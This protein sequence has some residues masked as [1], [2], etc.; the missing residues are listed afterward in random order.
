MHGITLDQEDIKRLVA[1]FTILQKMDQEAKRAAQSERPNEKQ[2]DKKGKLNYDKKAR[3]TAGP[4]LLWII[5]Y[6]LRH[7]KNMIDT[8][9]L[10]LNSDTYIITNPERFIPSARWALETSRGRH[11][12]ISKQNPTAKEL[13]A[14]I[15]KPRLTL[16]HRVSINGRYDTILKVELSLPKL[17]FG[18]NI[19]ELRLKDFVPLTQ[20]LV[21]VLATMGVLTTAQALAQAPMSKVHYSKNI[22]LT[23]GSTPHYYIS[24]IKEANIKFSLDVNQ[25]DYR[26][27]GHSF[28]WHCNSYEVAFYDKMHDL[29]DHIKTKRSQRKKFELLRMEVRLNKRQKMQALFK[30]LGIKTNLTLKS[31]FKP[32]TA[33]KVLLHYLDEVESKRPALLDYKADD[34][35]LLAALLVHNPTMTSKQILYIYGLKKALEVVSTREL[36]SMFEKSAQRSWSRLMAD[37]QKVKLPTT[38]NQF[39][40]VR[41]QLVKFKPLKTLKEFQMNYA[42]ENQNNPPK[43]LPH[44]SQTLRLK[45]KISEIE[46]IIGTLSFNVKGNQFYYLIDWP[47]ES[48]DLQLCL[49]NNEQ[50][51]RVN[52]I[53]FHKN[54]IHIKVEV[55]SPTGFIEKK[56]EKIDQQLLPENNEAKILYV[57]NFIL[58]NQPSVILPQNTNLKID[59]SPDHTR[60]IT[61]IP[62]AIDFSLIFLLIPNTCSVE[63]LLMSHA[64]IFNNTTISLSTFKK[65]GHSISRIIAFDGYDLLIFTTPY[66]PEPNFSNNLTPS[67][68]LRIFNYT[69]P[70]QSLIKIFE[71]INS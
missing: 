70:L 20:T 60:I 12:I 66:A 8:V 18:N 63:D 40:S 9:V 42:E 48:G 43:N 58:K 35:A 61:T 57:E 2:K 32:A 65:P 19:D 33:K 6:I 5:S 3:L 67:G 45:I 54:A 27:D 21:T 49:N 51:S 50:T 64:I 23:D 59:Y 25:T 10:L 15:Y 69:A 22:V 38:H 30:T 29:P 71:K 39:D 4:L 34:K 13:R 41:G 52:K 46:Y 26:N 24:K 36:R 47:K 37:V 55:S 56:L 53:S 62:Q 11:G 31:M 68:P 28:K 1:Y 17:L 7:L 44:K 14:G 16:S